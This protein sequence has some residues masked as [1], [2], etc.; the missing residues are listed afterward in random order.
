MAD[1]EYPHGFCAC[2]KWARLS[3]TEVFQL[4]Q[5]AVQQYE[6]YMRLADPAD[7]AKMSEI[8]QPRYSWDNPIGLVI[9]GPE[10]AEL[11]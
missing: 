11:V 9:S 4:L 3:E 2:Q 6:K 5:E 10:N 7:I 8:R 1:T